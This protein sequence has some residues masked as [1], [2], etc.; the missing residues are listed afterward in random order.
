MLTVSEYLRSI[1]KMDFKKIKK[2][3]EELTVSIKMPE[4]KGDEKK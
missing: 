4:K 1:K 2:E 3:Q